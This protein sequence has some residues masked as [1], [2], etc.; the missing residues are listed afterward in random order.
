MTTL[1]TACNPFS[2][3]LYTGTVTVF[4]FIQ[5]VEEEQQEFLEP[6]LVY[7][8]CT[9]LFAM[10]RRCAEVGIRNPAMQ[11]KLFDTLVLPISS[12]GV[13]VWG[14]KSQLG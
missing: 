11:C 9:V 5:K 1:H 12:Y 14:V 2:E 10:Q 4:S 3:S 8:S 6:V 13:E 7:S